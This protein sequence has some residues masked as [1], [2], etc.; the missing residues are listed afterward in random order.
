MSIREEHSVDAARAAA[1]R[2]ELDDWVARFLAAPGSDNPELAA[3]L[4]E[5]QSR[6]WLGPVEVPL[7]QLHRLAGPPGDPVLRALD[8]DEWRDDVDELARRIEGGVEPPPVIVT[9]RDGQLVLEDGNHRVEALRRAGVGRAWAVIGFED[10]EERDRFVA[11]S[12][13]DSG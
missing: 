4:T 13:T 11:R 10:P 7:D 9:Y 12:E 8:D 2:D 5:Q 6:W 1:E 3:H